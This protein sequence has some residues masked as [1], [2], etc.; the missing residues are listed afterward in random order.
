MFHSV[1][2]QKTLMDCL[3]LNY[4]LRFVGIASTTAARRV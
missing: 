2:S 4:L 1:A 3:E